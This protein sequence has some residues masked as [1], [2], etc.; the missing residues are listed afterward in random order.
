MAKV[1]ESETAKKVI[2]GVCIGITMFLLTDFI[3]S[4]RAQAECN[5]RQDTEIKSL[6]RDVDRIE[7]GME[8]LHQ[9]SFEI[10]Q[11]VKEK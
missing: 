1:K 4:R 7:D 2:V 9:I 5:V 3:V 10:L 11:A 6:R 8:R